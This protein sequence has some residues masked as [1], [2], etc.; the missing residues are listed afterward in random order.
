MDVEL[1][2]SVGAAK[3]R[4]AEF[5]GVAREMARQ[6]DLET[7]VSTVVQQARQARL[8]EAV[9]L[10]LVDARSITAVASSE[11]DVARADAL[12]LE[13]GE[14]P[15][16]EAIMRRRDFIS[17]DLRL[18]GRWRFWGPQAARLGWLSMLSVGLG[19]G[20]TI[21]AL[22]VYSRLPRFFSEEDLGVAEVFATHAALAVANARERQSLL[23]A[24]EARHLIGQAQGILMERYE[25]DAEQAFNVL[26]RYSSH[27]NRKLRLVA[28]EIVDHRRLPDDPALSSAG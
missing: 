19:D 11:P 26:R 18:D 12:Q 13:C 2:A 24:V 8:G 28:A 27:G 5:A 3:R 14:G 7:T 1:G 25:V 9:G 21:G 20:D 16:V 4:L 23:K 10:F 17:G 15:G 6:P 22:T